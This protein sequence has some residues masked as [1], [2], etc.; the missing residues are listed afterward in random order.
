MQGTEEKE[1][2]E[3]FSCFFSPSLVLAWAGHPHR[4]REKQTGSK[5][6]DSE[7][8]AATFQRH[9]KVGGDG[10]VYYRHL[11]RRFEDGAEPMAPLGAG[12]SVSPTFFISPDPIRPCQPRPCGSGSPT[13]L[14]GGEALP[15]SQEAQEGKL[16]CVQG[17][18]H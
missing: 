17:R 15:Q 3:S 4:C 6:S 10:D 8:F 14:P 2:M 1:K 12:L 7:S 5:F 9:G 11:Q 16:N 13:G 18:S